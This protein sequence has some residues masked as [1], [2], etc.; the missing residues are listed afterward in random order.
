MGKMREQ[1]ERFGAE[2]VR[3]DATKVD[4]AGRRSRPGSRTRSTPAR[5]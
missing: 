5:P 2:F 3:A 4:L 1:A